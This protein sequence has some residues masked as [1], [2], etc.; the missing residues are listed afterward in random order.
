MPPVKAA[1]A[2]I[3]RIPLPRVQPIIPFSGQEMFDDPTGPKLDRAVN[4]VRHRPGFAVTT[5]RSVAIMLSHGC[6]ADCPSAPCGPKHLASFFH[7]L[8]RHFRSLGLVIDGLGDLG[9]RHCLAGKR[10]FTQDQL[11]DVPTNASPS[12]VLGMGCGIGRGIIS[13]N[14]R[15]EHF[16]RRLKPF[17]AGFDQLG[18]LGFLFAKRERHLS[19]GF[20]RFQIRKSS[21]HW[22]RHR[23]S[24]FFAEVRL[25]RD[26]PR[27][28]SSNR[29]VPA[30]AACRG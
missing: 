20:Q 19:I 18:F 8:E 5:H 2:N 1:C 29:N 24:P 4:G 14:C 12:R 6:V 10:Q 27:K 21:L 17:L 25:L 23:S 30:A 26:R 7:A 22:R 11:A 16:H 9:C 15:P 28:R 3:L 13:R